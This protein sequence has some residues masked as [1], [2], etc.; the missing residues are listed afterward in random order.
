MRVSLLL[1]L[2]VFS[3]SPRITTR[4]HRDEMHAQTII[5]VD[6]PFQCL[7]TAHE[8][9]L[10]MYYSKLVQKALIEADCIGGA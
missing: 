8:R 7:V 2:T 5:V 9:S 6:R 1:S 4:G 3:C 10:E